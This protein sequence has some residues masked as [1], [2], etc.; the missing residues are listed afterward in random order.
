MYFAGRFVMSSFV[1]IHIP[2][3][4][5]IFNISLGRAPFPTLNSSLVNRPTRRRLNSSIPLG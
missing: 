2:G 1:F 5:F 3:G 4:S